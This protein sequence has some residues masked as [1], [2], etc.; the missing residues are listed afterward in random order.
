MR[1]GRDLLASTLC[2][3]QITNEFAGGGGEFQLEFQ[4]GGKRGAGERFRQ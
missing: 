4:R 1:L 2:C 3:G